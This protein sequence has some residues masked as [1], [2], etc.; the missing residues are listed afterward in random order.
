MTIAGVYPPIPTPFD[1]QGRLH[2]TA[3]AANIERWEQTGLHGYVVAGSNG[4]SPLLEADEIVEAVRVVRQTAAPDKRVI[5]G[6]GCQS[7][8][9]TLRL[10]RAVAE[11]GAGLA[12][13]MTPSFYP[14]QMTPA[15]LVRHYTTVADGSPIPILIYNVPKFTN[16]N[17]DPAVVAQLAAHPN[18]V[19]IK[20][21]AGNIG[22]VI[23]LLRLCPPD[24][25]VLLGNAPAFL[26]GLQVGA[27]GGILALANVAPAECVKIW[28]LVRQG[29]DAEAREIQFRLMALGKAV[30][31]GYGVPGLKAAL[32]ELGYYGGP[33]RPPLLPADASVRETIRRILVEARV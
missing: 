22:Q 12:L 19:G 29:R 16:L 13:V 33:P 21:S 30:T 7:T 26:S 15:A 31:A 1:E 18:I 8:A 2:A 23:D 6:T 32:D 25:E 20:D 14:T 10:T 24:F 4:E 5:A 17:L 3:L 9:A 11:A 28:R 27:V